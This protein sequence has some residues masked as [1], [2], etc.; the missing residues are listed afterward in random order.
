MP[1]G[2]PYTDKQPHLGDIVLPGRDVFYTD[3]PIDEG[4]RIILR[5]HSNT[6]RLT[7]AG[8]KT[9][10]VVLAAG[11]GKRMNP[12]AEGAPQGLRH[13]HAPARWMLPEAEARKRIVVAGKNIGDP[14]FNIWTGIHLSC[15]K[16]ARHRR[17]AL[18]ANR[19]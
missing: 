5:R 14:V 10:C 3:I 4:I 18:K 17:C 8:M 6:R 9:A 15:R 12:D 2:C 1:P 16:A 13:T 19:P 11:V 7:E